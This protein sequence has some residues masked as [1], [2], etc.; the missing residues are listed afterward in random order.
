MLN[1]QT[2]FLFS[3]RPKRKSR[4]RQLIANIHRISQSICLFA[5]LIFNLFVW[6]DRFTRRIFLFCEQI[7]QIIRVIYGWIQMIHAILSF[8]HLIVSR[9][10]LLSLRIH[11][12]CH[13][14]SILFQPL[15]NGTFERLVRSFSWIIF[16]YYSSNG[17]CYTLQD[18]TRHIA[19]TVKARWSKKSS[20]NNDDDLD[21]FYDALDETEG[22]L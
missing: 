1:I 12:L 16:Y 8:L 13:L 3:N 17:A 10:M 9:L 19:R 6:F 14:I 20:H 22:W 18:R 5:R 11:R 4:R 15:Y 2:L 7:Q 21:I